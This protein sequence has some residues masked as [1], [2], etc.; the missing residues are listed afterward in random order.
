MRSTTDSVFCSLLPR[1]RCVGI[2]AFLAL[3]ASLSACALSVP[4]QSALVGTLWDVKAKQAIPLEALI[5]RARGADIVLLGET[6][7]NPDHH[8]LQEWLFTA[9]NTD[10]AMSA[11]IMEQYDL[12]QQADIDAVRR[13]SADPATKLARLGDIMRS[14]WQWNLYRPLVASAL[15]GQTPLLAANMSRETLQQVSRKGFDA[16]GAGEADRLAL[17]SGWSPAQQKQLE[18][19]IF[20]GHCGM[21]PA[22]A[23]T[24]ISNAQRARDAVMADRLLAAGP[25]PVL[26][27]FGREH[28][29]R[30]LAVPLYL[31]Q[32]APATTVLAIGLIETDVAFV[33]DDFAS[34][35]MGQRYDY[36][37]MTAPVTRTVDPCEGLVMPGAKITQP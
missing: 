24:A 2:L 29:R 31:T 21:L 8:R 22:V 27:V 15:N 17:T 16:L 35:P 9:L 20:D 3:L 32:R 5:E 13:T 18:K 36:L 6:H 7:D 34:G 4:Q 14:G 28:V 37:V 1:L 26:A 30:D 19:N 10:G 23:A 33:P 12:E 11:L 25:G